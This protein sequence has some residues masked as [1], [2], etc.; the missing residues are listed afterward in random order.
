M[1]KISSWARYHPWQARFYIVLIKVALILIAIFTGRLFADQDITL[2]PV[3]IVISVIILF[4]V[5]IFYPEK[6]SNAFHKRKMYAMRK[7]CDFGLAFT[8]FI[9]ITALANNNT[10]IIYDTTLSAA[11]TTSVNTTFPPTAQEIL[12]SL[13][14]RDKSTLTRQEKRILKQELGKQIKSYAVAMASGNGKQG[15]KIALII[16]TIIGALGL[17]IIL[18]SLACSISCS[19]AE[20]LAIAV[21]I[22]GLAGI[23]WGTIA[24]I[25][26]IVKRHRRKKNDMPVT[27]Q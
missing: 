9:L 17:T 10:F 1:R 7:T 14:Y 5:L 20:G 25:S 26:S 16:L 15:E 4:S 13:K 18:A 6:T 21:T 11:S 2:S 27:G 3:L 23:I 12:A 8:T 22:V 24:I 19:G